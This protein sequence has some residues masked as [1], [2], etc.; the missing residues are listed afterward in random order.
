M[1]ERYWTQKKELKIWWYGKLEGSKV[2]E[3][4]WRCWKQNFAWHK[5]RANRNFNFKEQQILKICAARIESKKILDMDWTW[6][7]CS[8]SWTSLGCPL[9]QRIQQIILGLGNS[10]LLIR[11]IKVNFCFAGEN[12]GSTLYPIWLA[13]INGFLL[14]FAKEIT[15]FKTWVNYICFLNLRLRT[16]NC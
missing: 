3:K 8:L 1:Y 6:T 4:F 14:Q 7:S 11:K 12:Y 15:L 16:L 9:L 2:E 10:F 5:Q 13:K